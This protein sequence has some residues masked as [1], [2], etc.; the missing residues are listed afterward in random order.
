[1]IRCLPSS[2]SL[3]EHKTVKNTQADFNTFDS[4]AYDAWLYTDAEFYSSFSPLCLFVGTD[5]P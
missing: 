5:H 1:M 3:K 4:V 2:Q